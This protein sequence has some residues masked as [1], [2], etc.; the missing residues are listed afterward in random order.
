MEHVF[1]FP[2]AI[3]NCSELLKKNGQILHILPA[4]NFSG[5]GFYQFSPEFYYSVYSEE[6]GFENTEV[7]LAE[8]PEDN[9]HID[10]WYKTTKPKDGK[11]IEFYSDCA[12]GALVITKK[13]QSKSNIKVIQS[14]YV[15]AYKNTRKFVEIKKTNKIKEFL[16]KINFVKKNLANFGK[17][18]YKFN[19]YRLFKSKYLKN[20]KNFEKFFFTKV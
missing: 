19:K 16:K 17:I 3:K 2:Q 13:K 1:N 5:H 12:V 18:K 9:K 15:E 10:Y 6:N 20:N 8:Y 4:N 11:R 7:F 14:D